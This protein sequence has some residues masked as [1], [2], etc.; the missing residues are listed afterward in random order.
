MGVGV[1]VVL[2]CAGVMGGFAVVG[3]SVGFE[4]GGGGVKNNVRCE[5]ALPWKGAS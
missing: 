5:T 3:D 4:G 2:C 1:F